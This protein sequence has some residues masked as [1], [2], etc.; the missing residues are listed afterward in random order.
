M[1]DLDPFIR[2]IDT[3]SRRLE[4]EGTT[5]ILTAVGMGLKSD[6]DDA[7]RGDIG[8]TSMSGWTRRSKRNPGAEPF[9][10]TGRYEIEGTSVSVR[11]ANNRG[12]WRKGLGPMRVLESGRASYE[13][14]DKRSGGFGKV[15]KDGTRKEKFRT[16]NRRVGGHGGKGTWSDAVAL[17]TAHYGQLAEDAWRKLVSRSFGG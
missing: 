4:D 8:D 10:L 15:R 3:F 2:K 7:V 5:E 17:M 16:V 1:G 9:S 6:V 11:P 13:A 14:G 12:A